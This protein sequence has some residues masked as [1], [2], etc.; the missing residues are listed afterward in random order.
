LGNLVTPA[1]KDVHPLVG[2]MEVVDKDE[3]ML[4]TAGGLVTRV[5]AA[6]IKVQG[7]RTQG[8]R[9]ARPA[10]GDRVVEVTRVAAGSGGPSDAEGV[11]VGA[12]RSAAGGPEAETEAE[13]QS[14]LFD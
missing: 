11:P 4:V 8:S 1:G 9:L 2:A 14:D 10:A 5:A 13:D 7:R 3:V 6:T 12:S